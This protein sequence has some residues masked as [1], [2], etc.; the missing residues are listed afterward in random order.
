MNT[1]WCYCGIRAIM[2]ICHII[3]FYV[4][5]LQYEVQTVMLFLTRSTIVSIVQQ[6]VGERGVACTRQQTVMIACQN[7]KKQKKYVSSFEF[8]SCDTILRAQCSLT[9]VI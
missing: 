8:V 7:L 9:V 1:I 6:N 5:M 4:G 2:T 3:I